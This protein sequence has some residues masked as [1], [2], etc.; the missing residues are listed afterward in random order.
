MAHKT[1]IDGTT[2]E[3]TGGKSLVSGTVYSIASGKT[4][5]NGTSYGI[6]FTEDTTPT[7]MLYTDGNFVF[8]YG[9][10]H[11]GG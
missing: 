3:I 9:N 7:A 1:C 8:Q 4:L 2:Y 10:R 5:V 11:S 6:Y